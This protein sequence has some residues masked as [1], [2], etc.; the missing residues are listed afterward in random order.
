QMLIRPTFVDT[1]KQALFLKH[2]RR[3][4]ENVPTSLDDF[5]SPVPDSVPCANLELCIYLRDRLIGVTFLDLG[6]TATS[7]VYAIFDPAEAKRSLGILMMLHSIHFSRARGC[8]YYY[9]G[10]AYREPFAYD[11]KKR[12]TGLE[13]LDWTRG[14]QPYVVSEDIGSK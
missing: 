13:Y 8:R 10:Y 7:A 3:F 1:E 9:P 11:Y 12:F 6:Q 14:W 5:L 2:R 4:K